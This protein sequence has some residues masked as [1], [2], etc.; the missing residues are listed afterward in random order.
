MRNFPFLGKLRQLAEN[1]DVLIANRTHHFPATFIV[2]PGCEA[3]IESRSHA[4]GLDLTKFH[5]HK[6]PHYKDKW[7]I[8]S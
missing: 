4:F 6:K 1:A 3:H 7:K 2:V 5:R 8:K